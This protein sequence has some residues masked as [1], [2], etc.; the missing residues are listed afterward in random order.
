MAEI[1]R[2]ALFGIRVGDHEGEQH[3]DDEALTELD[4]DVESEQRSSWKTGQ[5][6]RLVWGSSMAILLVGLVL[7]VDRALL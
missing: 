5:E 1:N 4:A 6:P 3:C 7:F 2:V